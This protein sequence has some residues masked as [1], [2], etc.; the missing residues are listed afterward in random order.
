MLKRMLQFFL[1]SQLEAF[2]TGKASGG[3]RVLLNATYFPC[4]L[5]H[6]PL[7]V[8]VESCKHSTYSS[9]IRSKN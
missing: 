6:G 1:K 4:G 7:A 2:P 9:A 5:E 8:Q 3:L